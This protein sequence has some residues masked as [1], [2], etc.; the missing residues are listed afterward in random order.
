M[1]LDQFG[2][3][4][5]SA[6]GNARLG[7]L[8]KLTASRWIEHPARHR[9]LEALRQLHDVD[10]VDKSPQAANEFY[11]RLEKRMVPILDLF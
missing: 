5:Q 3:A 1:G 4:Q 11:L 2:Q 8:R 6:Y 9:D 10:L 7:L